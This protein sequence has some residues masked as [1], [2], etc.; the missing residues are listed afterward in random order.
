MESLSLKKTAPA[1][2]STPQ[3]RVQFPY[4]GMPQRKVK[5]IQ[6]IQ[7][8]QDAQDA[9][10]AKEVEDAKEAKEARDE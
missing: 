4:S 6:D 5:D 7:D 3:P 8:A 1:S 9:K 10:E 2:P